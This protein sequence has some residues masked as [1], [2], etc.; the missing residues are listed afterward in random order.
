MRLLGYQTPM[1]PKTCLLALCLLVVAGCTGAST[2]LTDAGAPVA[3]YPDVQALIQ[4]HC[5]TCHLPGGV[6]PFPLVTFDDAQAEHAALAAAVQARRMP[7]WMPSDGCLALQ[8]DRRLTDAEVAVFVDWSA[9]GAP[10]GDPSK[11][12]PFTPPDAGLPWV[13]VTLQPADAYLPDGALSDDY[14]CFSL[15]PGLTADQFLV[16]LDIVP[17]QRQLVHHVLLFAA[18]AADAQAA[19]DAQPGPG[20]TCF[21]G[22]GLSNAQPRLLGGW[23]PGSSATTF[24]DTTGIQMKAGE[25]VVM[26]VHY[27]LANGGPAPDRTTARLQLARG[28]I[29]KPAALLPL[30]DLTFAIPPSATGYS[31]STSGAAPATGLVWG[32]APHMHVKGRQISVEAG[33]GCLVEVPAWDFRWQQIYFFQSPLPVTAGTPFT[34]TCTW[35]N[36]TASTVTWGEGTADEMCLSY[37]YATL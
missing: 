11:A 33:G 10:E 23:V 32:V 2:S 31:S 13:D 7:P 3:Y 4:Q 6:A 16:G 8:G 14:H 21:G 36:P 37:L 34:L 35:D 22:P 5:E 17:E 19:D 29:A 26:Q 1:A 20:W 15:D 18:T 27:N 9:Q 25:V 24:P 28:P 12:V 30:A